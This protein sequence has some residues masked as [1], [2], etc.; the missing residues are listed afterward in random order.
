MFRHRKPFAV[1]I[2]IAIAFLICGASLALAAQ[3][4]S[5]N[6]AAPARAQSQDAPLEAIAQR[7]FGPA[8]TAAERKLLHA[9]PMR[10]LAWLGPN[11]DPDS[12]ANDTADADHWGPER[13]VRASIL[14][15]LA[16]DADA[17]RF[18]HPSGLGLA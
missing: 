8:L 18:V 17:S 15:W 13:V 7:K 3:A 10:A 2:A 9:A 14:S 5:A 16:S 12:R 1:A 4:A 11:D 6:L